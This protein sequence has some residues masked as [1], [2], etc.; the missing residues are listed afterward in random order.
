HIVRIDAAPEAPARI[1]EI[2]VFAGTAGPY[3]TP[4]ASGDAA[5]A[6]FVARH[7]LAALPTT[8][9]LEDLIEAARRVLANTDN[10]AS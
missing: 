3:C 5:D 9:G 4:R 8:P 1:Y 2:A 6:R 10:G 7:D